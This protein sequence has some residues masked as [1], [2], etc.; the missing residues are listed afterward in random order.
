MITNKNIAFIKCGWSERYK[1]D[2]VLGRHGYIQ[3]R[4]AHEKY[5]FFQHPDDGNYQVYIPPVRKNAPRPI[6]HDDWLLILVAAEEGCKPLKIVG[7]YK[8]AEF[9]QKYKERTIFPGDGT[10]I[11]PTDGGDNFLYCITAPKAVWVPPELRSTTTVSLGKRLGSTPIAYIQ[12][13]GKTREMHPWRE[14][15]YQAAMRFI[16]AYE[17]HNPSE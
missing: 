9:V 10:G 1:G 15:F 17:R 8:D 13:N 11:A 3:D 12:G 6:E 2:Q 7:W 16:N 5:N 14:N 4:E